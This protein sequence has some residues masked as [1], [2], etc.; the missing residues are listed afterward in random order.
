MFTPSEGLEITGLP[1]M[2][3]YWNGL[4]FGG[5]IRVIDAEN[6]YYSEKQPGAIDSD[7]SRNIVDSP[8]IC[9]FADFP[10]GPPPSSGNRVV[11]RF[12]HSSGTSSSGT[13]EE[14]GLGPI[15]DPGSQVGPISDFDPTTT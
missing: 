2:Y 6:H 3:Q 1:L 7:V 4:S 15:I 11:Y 5:D 8:I 12:T 13:S 9:V 14:P 10:A